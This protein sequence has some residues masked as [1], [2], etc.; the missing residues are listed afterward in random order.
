MVIK[1]GFEESGVQ[2]PRCGV[3]VVEVKTLGTLNPG[4]LEPYFFKEI[5]HD[6]DQGSLI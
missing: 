1:K 4:N 3:K 5:C 6:R 2:G